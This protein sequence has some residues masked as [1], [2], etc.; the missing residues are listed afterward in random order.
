MASK[1]KLTI[2]KYKIRY[3]D[4]QK[5]D[6]HGNPLRTGF[7]FNGSSEQAEKERLEWE[8][9]E[10]RM[11]Q[12]FK[13][14]RTNRQVTIAVLYDWFFKTGLEWKNLK[15]EKPIKELTIN[16]YHDAFANFSDALGSN[17][18]IENLD[19][20]D[21]RKHFPKRKLN[22]LNVDIRAMKS[23]INVAMTHKDKLV[24]EMPSELFKFTVKSKDPYYL[25]LDQVN[26]ILATPMDEETYEI[27]VMY[28][29]TGCR[30]NGLLSLTWDRVDFTNKTIKVI[31]KADK[32]RTIFVPEL[33]MDILMKYSY[34][35]QPMGYSAKKVGLRLAKLSKNS[36]IPFTSRVLR[37]TCGSFMLS[38]GCS[39]EQVAE[40]LG[41]ADIQTTRRWYARIIQDQRQQA[42]KKFSKFVS[43]MVQEPVSP[44]ILATS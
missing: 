31:E 41:H 25:E 13:F 21:F 19:S 8:K 42:M 24:K 7:T 1:T 3:T 6:R 44:Y 27:F 2:N 4:Y 39:I 9:M 5:K 35:S 37:S 20:T 10:K 26:K 43:N 29:Y 40:H 18:P 23:I 15:R 12:G 14:E 11:K 22:G 38:S 32:E 30:L 17:C 34:R 36:G 33:V 16:K 28:L